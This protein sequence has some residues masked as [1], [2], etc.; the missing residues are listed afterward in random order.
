[1]LTYV[2]YN[3]SAH[4]HTSVRGLD[5][6]LLWAFPALPLGFGRS[7]EGFFNYTK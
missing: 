5:L 6:R 4:A 1:M 2:F 7:V 3:N